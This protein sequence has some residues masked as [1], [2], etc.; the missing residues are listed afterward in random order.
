MHPFYSILG[1]LWLHMR[2]RTKDKRRE[3]L[4]EYENRYGWI[5]Y[6][7]FMTFLLSMLFIGGASMIVVTLFS[8][9]RDIFHYLKSSCAFW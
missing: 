6:E 7:L 1:W 8:I 5:G 9:F 4:E 2:Y 3:I